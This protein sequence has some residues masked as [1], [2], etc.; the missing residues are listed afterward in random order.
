MNENLSE[1]Q[2]DH[3]PRRAGKQAY[4]RAGTVKNL[5]PGKAAAPHHPGAVSAAFPA[6]VSFVSSPITMKS[7]SFETFLSVSLT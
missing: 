6:I 7:S 2:E 4:W 3:G 5:D 1:R